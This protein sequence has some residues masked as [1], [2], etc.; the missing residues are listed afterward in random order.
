MKLTIIGATGGIGRRIC[1]QAVAA[2][3]DVTAIVRNP[4]AQPPGTRAVV[5]D[6]AAPDPAALESALEGA[7]AVLSAL[8]PRTAADAGVVARGT[9]A[10]VTAMTAVGVR[11]LIVVSAAPIGTV[12]VPGRPNPPRHDPGDGIVMRSLLSPLIKRILR[13]TYADLALMEDGLRAG[14]VDWTIVRPPRL[15]DGPHT[16]TYRTAHDR[17]VRRGLS[18]SRADVADLMLDLVNRP[19]TIG[20]T[21]GIAY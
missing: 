3:H 8:G 11:R 12:P 14:L 16:R 10:L 9:N 2:G 7:D 5:A 6:L 17:N 4:T 1:A 18:I 13:V 20:H 21:I 15:T 19:D